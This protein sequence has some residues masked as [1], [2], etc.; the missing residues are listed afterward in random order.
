M[1]REQLA[2]R[3]HWHTVMWCVGIMNAGFMLPQL[4][5]IWES[6]VTTGLSLVT[7]V[8]NAGIQAGFMLHGFFIRNRIVMISNL[9]A[10]I[11]SISTILSVFYFCTGE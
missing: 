4:F 3:I 11:V 10:L 5:Q 1:T 9:I 8:M 7:F 6:G 2:Q